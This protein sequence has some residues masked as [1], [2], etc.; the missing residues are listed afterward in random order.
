MSQKM[1]L[2]VLAFATP[3]PTVMA[4]E[5]IFLT[6]PLY[7]EEVRTTAAVRPATDLTTTPSLTPANRNNSRIVT[8]AIEMP[9]R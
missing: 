2:T 3:T 7:R 5:A 9:I 6:P 8:E 1:F 4:D